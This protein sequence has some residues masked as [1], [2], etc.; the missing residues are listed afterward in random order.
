MIKLFIE[1][2]MFM[3]PMTF[4]T[5]GILILI[6]KKTIDLF[7]GNQP[8]HQAERGL[9]AI[10]FWGCMNAVLGFFSHFLGVYLAMGEIA[11]ANDISPAIV[12]GRVRWVTQNYAQL[13]SLVGAHQVREQFEEYRTKP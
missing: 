7:Q 8:M 1:G 2:G 13:G 12:A 11:T 5:I 10:L 3:W 4:I 6:V 9:N